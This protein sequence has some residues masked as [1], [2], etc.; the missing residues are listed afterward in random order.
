MENKVYDYWLYGLPTIGRKTFLKL[1]ETGCDSFFLYKC[2]KSELPD[3]L[4]KKQK[5]FIM[6]GK[7][8]SMASL[9]KSFEKLEKQGI[10]MTT[11]GDADYPK[12]LSKIPDAPAVLF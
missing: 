5:D 1:Q 11:F 4:S 10:F 2:D 9:E 8:R 3:F 12:R 7:T 6:K